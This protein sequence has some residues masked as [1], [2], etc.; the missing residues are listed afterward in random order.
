MS[1]IL[2]KGQ[3]TI[4][5]QIYNVQEDNQVMIQIFILVLNSFHLTPS[6]IL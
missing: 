6:F 5:P 3:G 4:A 2:R 1:T